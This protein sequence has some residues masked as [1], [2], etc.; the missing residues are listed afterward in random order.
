MFLAEKRT[1]ERYN[2]EPIHDEPR[3][4][5]IHAEGASLDIFLCTSVIAA[6]L[7]RV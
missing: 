1:D 5:V 4:L 6:V 2:P 7:A 3:T